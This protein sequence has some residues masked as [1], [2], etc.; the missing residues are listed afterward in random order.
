MK[1]KKIEKKLSLLILIWST[2]WLTCK[3]LV[4]KQRKKKH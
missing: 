1:K 2:V 4:A 3:D